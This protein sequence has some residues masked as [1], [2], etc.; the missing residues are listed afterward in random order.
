MQ[1][2]APEF[3]PHRDAITSVA[4]HSDGHHVLTASADGSAAMV[5]LGTG[6]SLVLPHPAAVRRAR[7]SADEGRIATACDDGSVR[8]WQ[9]ESGQLLHAIA[10]H[11]G[12]VLDAQF[13]AADRLVLS[14]GQ[15]GGVRVWDPTTGTRAFE[16]R[17]HG[18]ACLCAAVDE[19]LGLIAT[20]G[21][22]HRVLV[23]DL[24]GKP[25]AALDTLDPV[26]KPGLVIEGNASALC[27]DRARRRLVVANRCD[28]MVV[29]ELDG[30]L[31]RWVK[32]QDEGQQYSLH[33]AFA[34][35]G[36]FYATAHSGV[37]DWTFVD[38]DSLQPRD[39]GK[40]GF[41]T[42]IVSVLR[43]SPDARLLLVASRDDSVSLWDLDRG[44]RHLELRARHGGIRAA[45]F[46]AD[47]SWVVTGSQDGTLRAW[48]VQPLPFAREHH[49]RLT[50]RASGQ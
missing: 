18:K 6:R 25:V 39:V 9:R 27:F 23:H 46:R 24:A 3:R 22:D 11:Q 36:R 4:F 8:I 2:P 45:E 21:A 1:A 34:P 43:F 38:A 42:A 29:Y 40:Q 5:E 19:A 26:R 30:W 49:A 16:L 37:G 28:V 7:L 12:P 17:A 41:P 10:A 35:G 32:P 14:I 31:P 50:G 44:E 20:G 47:G 13:F 15:D 48:P 33:L